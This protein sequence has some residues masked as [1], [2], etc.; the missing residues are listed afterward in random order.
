[1]DMN[2]GKV[3]KNI[4]E[5]E[6]HEEIVS[7]LESDDF[8]GILETHFEGGQIVRMKKSETILKKDL[9]KHLTRT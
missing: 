8:Y 1:M 2:H 3:S 7:S 6:K 4:I 5:R 9:E